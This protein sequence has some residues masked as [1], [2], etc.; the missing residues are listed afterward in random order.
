LVTDRVRV[1]L[2]AHKAAIPEFAADYLDCRDEGDVE[3][4]L[5][6]VLEERTPTHAIYSVQEWEKPQS[7]GRGQMAPSSRSIQ[8]ESRQTRKQA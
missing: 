1:P 3:L 2:A 8:S 6:F 4:P 5:Y 7:V